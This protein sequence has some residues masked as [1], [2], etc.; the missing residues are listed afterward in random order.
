MPGQRNVFTYA[1]GY[2]MAA[3]ASCRERRAFITNNGERMTNSL[4]ASVQCNFPEEKS[5]IL[6]EQD[7]FPA[8]LDSSMF[9]KCPGNAGKGILIPASRQDFFFTFSGAIPAVCLPRPS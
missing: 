6:F 4:I 1:Q 8:P 7:F 5:M 2:R 3:G 9:R